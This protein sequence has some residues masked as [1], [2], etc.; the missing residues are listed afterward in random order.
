MKTIGI[1]ILIALASFG[2]AFGQSALPQFHSHTDFLLASPGALGVG[3]YGYDN[4]ALLTYLHKPDLYVAWSDINGRQGSFSRWGAFAAAPHVGFGAVHQQMPDGAGGNYAVTDYRISVAFGS[5]ARSFGVSYGWSGGDKSVF[6]RKNLVSVGS[7]VRPLPY[8]SV[9]LAGR[10]TLTGNSK[11]GVVDV[12]V[13][14]L[15]NEIIT[16]FSDYAIQNG[17][18]LKEGR[19]SIGA[20]IEPL[21]G[22]RLTGRYFDTKSYSIG[23]N[24]SLGAAGLTGQTHIDRNGKRSHNTYGIRL[25]A[26]DR[27]I[28][29]TFFMKEKRYLELDLYGP[30]KYQRFMFFDRSKTLSGLVS[31]IDAA[32]EDPTIKG[33]AINI[34]G[35]VINQEMIWELREKLKDFKSGGKHV[36]IYVDRV[37]IVGYHLASVADKIIMDPRGMIT[38]QGFVTGRTF[39]RGTLE[40]LGLAF[41]EWRFFE[42]KSAAEAFSRDSMSAADR[43]QR[44][45]MV[46]EFYGL[47]RA[48][49]CEGR[50]LTHEQF[51]AFVD[52]HPLFLPHEAIEKGLVDTL[53][54]W[55][56][57]KTV[58]ERLEGGKKRLVG[59]GSLARNRLPKD[60]YWGEKPK[61][62]VI[63]ALG[64]CAMDE[65]ITAR[66]LVKDVQAATD[67]SGVKAVVLRVDSP[68]GDA[69]AS[70]VIA[71]A[72]RKCRE[73]KPVIIS[74]GYVAKS[75]GYWLSMYGD[76]IVS[77][78]NSI[79]GSIG[80]IG[81][82]LYNAG[83]KEKLGMSTDKVRAG[84][85][86]DLGFGMT[87]PF[88]GIS[89]PDRN[90]TDDERIIM[91][92]GIKY[93]YREFVEKVASGRSMQFDDVERVAQGRVW[94]GSDAVQLGL[95][96]T[97]GGLETAILI[98]KE[99]AGIPA[100]QQVAIVEMP[101]P[102]MLDLSIFKP[103][104]L[105][106]GVNSNNA[107]D[108][109]RFRLERNG[110]PLLLV[111][112]EDIDFESI[113]NRSYLSE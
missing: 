35:M 9:G 64:V 41:D 101:K 105:G 19:W 70:D 95:V 79:T 98:A 29:Q 10:A 66:K 47:V 39:F 22:I 49:V 15:R 4:P 11:E 90:L 1:I 43:E 86:A 69:L 89:I 55:D 32:K 30:L 17:V 104:I 54:R 67:D 94:T 107:V 60:S 106:V 21:P 87:L 102:G 51:D 34:S 26:Y 82:W 20:A 76:R 88:L 99:R 31:D 7:L 25:G 103:K 110:Q 2:Y 62:A 42:Y 57:V 97:L 77:A 38:L 58:I 48:D 83:F 13:R 27:N 80:V 68:G 16:L 100:H 14:P 37:G 23:V 61:I 46:D 6:G 53:G 72:L 40:K 74:Q 84:R 71:E 56:D 91:E 73:K 78:P 108:H 112:L 36:V 24:L 44:Q 63:Y 92:R 12:A 111:P 33:I 52:E 109:L 45:K 65:G 93:M 59:S 28:F 96:D 113:A 5:L 3:L 81:G 50:N 18:P 8:V 75:G 85:H